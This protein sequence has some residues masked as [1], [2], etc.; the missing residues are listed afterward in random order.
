MNNQSS[1]NRLF[2][3]LPIS[4]GLALGIAAISARADYQSTVV[5]DTPVAYYPL[6]SDVDPTGTTAT[7]LSGNGN[8]GTYNGTDPEF[9][10]VPGP[11]PYLANAL[12]FDGF[13][14]FVDLGTGPNTGSL[15]F[16]GPTTLEAWVQPAD[17]T[18]FGDIIGKGYLNVSGYPEIAL[19]VNGQYGGNYF[20]YFGGPGVSGG[21]QNTAWTYVV[22]SNDGTNTSLYINGKLAQSTPDTTGSITFPTTTQWAIGDGTVDGN[23]RYFK[24]NI[25]QAAIYNHGLSAD[26]VLNHYY[27]G[28]LNASP[29]VSAPI[30]TQQ[31]QPQSTYIG[32]SVTFGVGA[33]SA[34]ATTNQWF[35]N[36]SPI[37]GQTNATLTLNNVQP[38]DDVGY[39]VVVGNINGTTNSVAASLSLFTPAHL[40]WSSSGNSGTWDTGSSANWVNLA[41]SSQT[42]FNPGDQVLFDDSVGAPTTVTV[43][44]TVSPSLITVDSS[45]NNFN[46]SSGTINGSGGLVKK[47]S[48]TLSLF[49]SG[50]LTGPVMISGGSIYAGNNCFNSVVSITVTN[51]GTLDLGGGTFHGNKPI[52]V[53]GFGAN[54]GGAIN[55]TYDDY[56]AQSVSI[57]LAGDTSFGASKRWDLASGSFVGGPH[58][59]TLNL[60]GA[61]YSEWT[62]TTIGADVMNIILTN[63]NFGAKGMSSS[64]QNPGTMFTVSPN[65]QLYFWNSG[66][67]WNGSI[68]LL[69]GAQIQHFGAPAGFNGTSI[70]LE[71]GAD[72]ASF[73]NTDATTP[74]NS[75]ITLN[76]IARFEFGDH[77]MVFTNLISGP[78]GF[79]WNNW[80]HQMVISASNTYAG[81]TVLGDGPQVALIGDGSIS[82]SSLIFFGG[83]NSSSVHMDVSGR[84]DQTL[85][86]VSGQTLAGVGA[87]NGKLTVHP[88]ATLSPA[89]TN[90]TIGITSGTN[91][92]GTI[93]A[94]S[95]VTLDG[96][97]IIKLNGSGVNDQVQSSTSIAYSGILN[98]T[99]ISGSPLAV[100][101]SFQILNAPSYSGSFGSI[102]PPTP[103][104]NLAWDTSQLNTFGIINVVA[105]SGSG[106]VINSTT[107]A[108]GNLIF[109]GTGGTA[110]GSYVVFATT[111]LTTSLANWTPLQTNSFDGVGAFSV[112]NAIL[113]S[114]PQ[115]FYIIK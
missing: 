6:N 29:S 71:T 51:D 24:G 100:G 63:G 5:G 104:A 112:T 22:L 82:H 65:G 110:N 19:R 56:P 60:T 42:V 66:D 96:T 84:S 12:Q 62:S 7:D 33:V 73:Y 9:N 44:G 36:G 59:L 10:S 31:P 64:F 97:T 43:S 1:I 30:I 2:R 98:L 49:N 15:Q 72:F 107:V 101:N 76:G 93:S 86:L 80:N 47:G 40:K 94:W 28:E 34:F 75:A 25:C 111:N 103:G 114:T 108:G 50:T 32:G 77:N 39:S 3:W 18:T 83:N 17:S 78:G 48:S 4:L 55:N 88:G 21:Q 37:K 95:D 70:I 99:N 8:T 69:N 92:T 87:V 27:F 81:P 11:T 106:P 57:T 13:T 89:G 115:Q 41:N 102:T 45:I 67:G 61:N 26:Q 52:T 23:T 85:A 79:V 68:H 35:K 91:A 53:S 105:S 38:G 20:G 16:T 113:L 58:G 46:I 74:V 90:T 14:S 109:S 54:G